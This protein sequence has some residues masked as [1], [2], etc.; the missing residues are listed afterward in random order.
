MSADEERPD[1]SVQ[2]TA[3]GSAPT[4]DSG[5]PDAMSLI[6]TC[7]SLLA[8]RAWQAMGLVPNS[9]TQSIERHFDEAQL[10]IDAA[11]ALADLLRPRV[12]DRERREL[13][14]LVA[15]LR[16]NFVEQKSKAT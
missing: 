13:E 15:N 9:A 11:A 14:T 2:D 6:A 3:P 12:G 16:I 8:N 1:A 7:I 5:L 10:A 4:T